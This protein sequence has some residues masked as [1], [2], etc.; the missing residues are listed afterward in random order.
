MN[1]RDLLGVL[2]LEDGRRW[3]DA[4]HPFQREDAFAV[5]AGE[6][7]YNFLTRARG[8]SKTTDLAAVALAL[9]LTASSASRLYWLAADSDQGALAIDSIAGFVARTPQLQARVD[10]QA[11]RVIAPATGASLQVL[12]ADAPGAYGLRPS[13][14]FVDEL[15]QWSDT[16]APRRLWEAVSTAVAKSDTARLVVLTTAGDPSHFAAKVLEHARSSP[17]WRV[18]EVPGPAPWMSA[19]RLAEQ[20][21][22]LPE[23]AYAR[24][25]LNRWVEGEDRLTT[26]DAVRGCVS[27]D[28]ALEY[29]RQHRYLV[30]LDLGLKRDRTVAA[31]CHRD[32]ERVVVARMAVWQG[33]RLKPVRLGDVEAWIKQAAGEYGGARVVADPW[34]AVGLAQRLRA[35]GVKVDEYAFTQQSVGRLAST[36]Y[37]LLRDQ[38]LGLPD[39]DELLDELAHLRL[40]ETSPGA[41]RIDH[42]AGR[43]DDRAISI[44]LAAHALLAAP[45]SRGWGVVLPASEREQE[46]TQTRRKAPL[47]PSAAPEAQ[48]SAGTAH[49]AYADPETW[50]RR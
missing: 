6:P 15:A 30:G 32:G 31:V 43:H 22:R 10:V 18:H 46:A 33:S 47:P 8:A 1:A 17:L 39:D 16:P 20:R 29:D 12:A 4:A 26:A 27:H 14:V 35:A 7:P 13:A 21:A 9:L 3:I 36:L 37:N 40:R 38:A 19:E 23:S 45:Q 42:Q 25:F 5:L 34:Q 50:L 24:L 44:A 28:G 41:Y 11:R 48:A 49:D 2:V